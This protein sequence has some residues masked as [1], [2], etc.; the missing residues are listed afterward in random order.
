MLAS[1]AQWCVYGAQ[2]RL[3]ARRRLI[4]VWWPRIRRSPLRD[5]F[6]L[7][8]GTGQET[9]TAANGSLLTLLSIDEAAA[10]GDVIDLGILD[11]CWSLDEA[12]EQAI[13]PGMLTKP[14]AQLWRLSTAG[15]AKSVVLAG[16]G[17][18]RPDR[19]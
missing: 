3:A 14:N 1:P 12:A 2:S 17:G 6:E 13:R 8:K 15:T 19:G 18:R 10:H 4:S 5:L 7:S 16:P 11:E 9:L